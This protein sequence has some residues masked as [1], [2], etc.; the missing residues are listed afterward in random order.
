ME[1]SLNLSDLQSNSSSYEED[2]MDTMDRRQGAFGNASATEPSASYYRMQGSVWA[3]ATIQSGG[4]TPERIGVDCA[5]VYRLWRTVTGEEGDDSMNG[6]ERT[7]I[8][9]QLDTQPDILAFF[10]MQPNSTQLK[11]VHSLSRFT[12][13]QDPDAE[14]KVFEGKTIAFCGDGNNP[15]ALV[16]PQEAFLNISVSL[17]PPDLVLKRPSALLEAQETTGW[18]RTDVPGMAY[19]PGK[20][21]ETFMKGSWKPASAIDWIQNEVG[22]WTMVERAR[23]TPLLNW[24]RAASVQKSPQQRNTSALAFQWDAI[25]PDAEFNEW[26]TLRLKRLL[27]SWRKPLVLKQYE[28]H[29]KRDAAAAAVGDS[30]SSAEDAYAGAHVFL[31]PEETRGDNYTLDEL[32]NVEGKRS[33]DFSS[34]LYIT[35][36]NVKDRSVF[37]RT[38]FSD[39]AEMTSNLNLVRD[40]FKATVSTKNYTSAKVALTELLTSF[41]MMDQTHYLTAACILASSLSNHGE[42][43]LF[44]INKAMVKQ[45]DDM[46]AERRRLVVLMDIV[47]SKVSHKRF[48]VDRG[49]SNIYRLVHCLTT[50]TT[51]QQKYSSLLYCIFA[52]SLQLCLLAYVFIE[53]GTIIKRGEI[54]FLDIYQYRMLPLAVI[55]FFFSVMLAYPA[56][57][58][59][60]EV[61]KFYDSI[62]ILWIIDFFANVMVP[63]LIVLSGFFIISLA[64][65]YIEAVLNSTALFFIAEIDDIL[66]HLLGMD[67]SSIVQDYLVDKALREYDSVRKLSN[68]EIQ[69]RVEHKI[70][71][72]DF[73]DYFLTNSKESGACYENN[74]VFQPF[75]VTEDDTVDG[76]TQ[77]AIK[78]VVTIGCIL[79]SIDW[80]YTTGFPNT[81]KPRIGYLRLVRW[82]GQVVEIKHRGIDDRSGNEFTDSNEKGRAY[83]ISGVLLITHFR[84]ADS[85][86]HLRVCGSKT[87]KDFLDAFQYYS[88]WNFKHEVKSM[89]LNKTDKPAKR[90]VTPHGLPSTDTSEFQGEA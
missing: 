25:R 37:L 3:M 58:N 15:S 38:R 77:L 80:R 85:V 23:I 17:P 84:M 89:L 74:I 44:E 53:I 30:D 66:P 60:V 22:D 13:F 24:L 67:A 21:L 47:F 55:S 33:K 75:E 9:R 70:P 73:S 52:I 82:D 28:Q 54:D 83:S 36:L 71:K 34:R 8:Q 32:E 18:V 62:S 42:K 20:W 39:N 26:S 50:G 2:K 19:I 76:E 64:D 88:L 12:G 41:F 1:D 6:R 63:I 86:L 7:Y 27:R 49:G 11:L 14:R 61:Y 72:I 29:L 79:K 69:E 46:P 87:P 16:C 10:T 68:E 40:Y 78:N 43:T 57:K 45:A 65:T 4:E 81:T 48:L 51:G 56:V 5:R 31:H 35:A 59:A 90:K